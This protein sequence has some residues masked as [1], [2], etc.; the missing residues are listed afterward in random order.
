MEI[1]VVS[2][3]GIITNIRK[4][5][6][7]IQLY[8]LENDIWEKHDVAAQHPDIVKPLEQLMKETTK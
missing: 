2:D 1:L 7:Q 4:G 8:N 5:N 3:K 6:T